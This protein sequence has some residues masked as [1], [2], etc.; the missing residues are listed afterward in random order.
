MY[1]SG[2]IQ[3][4]AFGLDTMPTNVI[5]DLCGWMIVIAFILKLI[6]YNAVNI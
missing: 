4:V 6:S 3:K 5:F 2:Q 1:K